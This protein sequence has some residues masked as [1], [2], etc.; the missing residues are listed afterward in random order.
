MA[1][2]RGKLKAP[3]SLCVPALPTLG[4]A[5]PGESDADTTVL[6]ALCEYNTL[7]LRCIFVI[8]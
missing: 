2:H 3:K 6:A 4:A 8:L 1:S 5:F 7:R